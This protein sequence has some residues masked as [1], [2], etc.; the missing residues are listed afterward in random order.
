MVILD[1]LPFLYIIY[2][3]RIMENLSEKHIVSA[4]VNYKKEYFELLTRI[5]KVYPSA[6]MAFGLIYIPAV[7]C[8]DNISTLR[9]HFS[10]LNLIGCGKFSGITEKNISILKSFNDNVLLIEDKT[11]QDIARIEKDYGKSDTQYAILFDRA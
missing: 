11:T 5:K 3:L 1:G 10:Y 9:S 6:Y 4:Y 7:E 8:M 2:K